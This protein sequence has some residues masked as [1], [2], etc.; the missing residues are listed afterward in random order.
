M[1]VDRIICF[2]IFILVELYAVTENTFKTKQADIKTQ[3][4]YSCIPKKN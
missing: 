4:G 1:R 2:K 3:M